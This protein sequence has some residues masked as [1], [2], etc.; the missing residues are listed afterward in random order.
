MKVKLAMITIASVLT[1]Y[2]GYTIENSVYNIIDVTTLAHELEADAQLELEIVN[3]EKKSTITVNRPNLQFYDFSMKDRAEINAIAEAIYYEARGE[4]IIGMMAVRQVLENRKNNGSFGN[5]YQEVV[6]R[7]NNGVPEFE[8]QNN[9]YGID[10]TSTSYK[11]ALELAILTI[12]NRM[13]Y[14]KEI[15][16]YNY[17]EALAI[18][19][20]IKHATFF[21]TKKLVY[22]QNCNGHKMNQAICVTVGNHVF[23]TAKNGT[24][25]ARRL[26]QSKDTL[27]LAQGL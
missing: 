21:A 20:K 8:Y 3:S 24:E 15:R 12:Q 1:G 6:T 13:D 25:F 2:I 18:I 5:T 7:R 27:K 4:G 16:F 19:D 14:F 23:V 10:K 11:I 9:K 22:N 17:T 26:H